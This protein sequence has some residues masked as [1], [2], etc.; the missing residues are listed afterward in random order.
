MPK[1]LISFFPK[2]YEPSTSQ[3]NIIKKVDENFS[4]NHKFCI[5]SAPTGTGKSFLS[6]TLANASN[7]P[8]EKFTNLINSY[9]AYKQDITG[10]YIN[11]VECEN[12][13]PFGS[14]TL[15]I[16]KN[17]QDQYKDL[18]QQAHLLKG[19]NN[20][21]CEIDNISTVEAAPCLIAPRL[22][23]DCWKQNRC[24]YYNSRNIALTSRHSILNYKMFLHLPRHLKRKNYI[25]CDEAS[26]LENEMV[27]MY[28]L[29]LDINKLKHMGMDVKRPKSL[30]FKD[31]RDWLH[32]ISVQLSEYIEMLIKEYNKN[33]NLVLGQKNKISL[34]KN[35]YMQINQTLT[36]WLSC[37]WVIDE[38]EKNCITITPLRVDALTKHIFDYA[39][40]VVLM[41]ATIIDHKKFANNLGITKYAYIEEKSNFNSE[42][43]PIY[44]TNT[45]PV[46]YSNR[47]IA[48]PKIAK[49]IKELCT[50]YKG[51]KGIIHTQSMEITNL[52][53]KHLKGERF[54]FRDE[55]QSN[56]DMLDKHYNSIEPTVLVSPSLSYGVDLRDDL[57]RFCIIVKLPYL[58]LGNK[59]VKKLFDSDK[60]WYQNQ[61]LNTLVQMCG[62]A[63]RSKQDYSTTYILDGNIFKVIPSVVD[64]LPSHFV[65]RIK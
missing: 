57:A 45:N 20:Y 31:I 34:F 60:Q 63:T 46:N 43:S 48:I 65:D 47:H 61:M 9:D 29:F 13:P 2:D 54:L 58:P 25:I 32:N 6:M 59:R 3:I 56:S 39:D 5:V 14:F 40:Q 1:R 51:E 7:E 17:L 64:K 21:L 44:I 12:E 28:S 27:K 19:K 10:N 38:P 24:P 11:Q 33:P 55:M 30:F 8:S 35:L 23:D 50:T 4:S 53:R 62:R 49:Q 41:S 42:L 26:E 15:T 22:K 36:E 52:L 18:F 16:T 37:E